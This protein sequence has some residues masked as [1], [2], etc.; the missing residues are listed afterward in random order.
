MKC[1]K[2]GYDSSLVNPNKI[3]S[4]IDQRNESTRKA[5]RAIV[6]KI[7]EH[8]Y[9]NPSELYEFLV[10]TKDVSDEALYY[11]INKYNMQNMY[12]DKPLRYLRAMVLN[13]ERGFEKRKKIEYDMYG[14]K[15]PDTKY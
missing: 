7:K 10:D 1:P 8:Q 4:L 5:I 6:E 3:R 15:P 14:G 12:T 11:I 9:M 2:C 13:L